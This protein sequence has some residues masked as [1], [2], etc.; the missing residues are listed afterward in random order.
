MLIDAV[1]RTVLQVGLACLVGFL[2][3]LAF[4]VAYP[5]YR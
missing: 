2:H 1:A 5:V 3:Q 4:P